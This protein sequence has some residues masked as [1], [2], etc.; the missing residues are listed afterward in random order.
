[1]N[2]IYKVIWSRAKNCYVVVSELAGS[3]V[4]NNSGNRTKVL[5]SAVLTVSLL[6]SFPADSLAVDTATG[7]GAGV[8]YG[9]GSN[10]PKAENV[11]IGKGA[12]ISY[13]GGVGQPS[14]GDIAIG[15]GARTLNY[16]DQ[17][18]GIA[19]G[20]NAF[21]ENMV[22]GLERSFDFNQAGYNSIFGMPYGL[23]KDPTK[24]VTG[25]TIGQNT[26]A[27]S[28]SVMLGTHNYK[29]ALGDISVDT[30]STKSY[31]MSLFS[32]TL[33]ANSFSNGLFS[34]VTGAYSIAS[35]DYN[36]NTLAAGK[37]FGAT[38]TGALNSIESATASSS[39]AGVA[40]SIV[41]TANREFNSN[42]ALIFGAGN[43]ITNSITD[44]SAPTSSG[45]S[46]QALQKTLMASVKKSESGG[47]TL[48]IG[49]G[50]KA[51]YTQKTSIIGVNNTVTGTSGSVSRY[52][53]VNGYKNTASNVQHVSVIGSG[54][55]VKDTDTALLLGDNRTLSGATNSLV[56]GS[57]DNVTT[58]DQQNVVVLGHNANATVAG[59]VALG[60][61]SL[62]AVEAGAAGYDPSTRQASTDTSS[63][64]V[65]TGAAVS[66]GKGTELTRQ[67]TSVAAGTQD[68]DAVNVAQLKQ[69][70][71]AAAEVGK[72]SVVSAG[73][74]ISVQNTAGAG[75][76]ANYQVSLKKDIT[77]DSVTAQ[78]ASVGGIQLNQGN[79]GTIG[80]LQNTT[81][82]PDQIVSGQAATEDQLK[83]VTANVVSYDDASHSS[84][85]LNQ[86]GSS[87]VIKNVGDGSVAEGSKEAVNGGQ[88]YRTNQAVEKNAGDI[89]NLGSS[90]N[91]LGSRLNRVG[92]GAAALAALH[93]QDFD[94]DDKWDFA[95]GYGNYKDAHAA[96]IGAFYRPSEDTLISVGGSFGGGENMVNAGVTFKLGQHNHV[97]RSKV[98]MA[99]EIIDLRAT[100]EMLKNQNAQ[101]LQT[102]KLQGTPAVK[103]L[104]GNFSD[105]PE[106]HWA[107]Q[108]VEGLR[109]RGYLQGYPDGEFK[110]DRTMTRYEYAAI[111]YRALQNGAPVDAGMAR[112][113]EE[114]KPE[115][116]QVQEAERFRV[117][118]ISGKDNDRHKVERVR[119]NSKE[120]KEKKEY[121]DVYGSRIQRD[122]K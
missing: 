108:Y 94:P 75:E 90:V 92:A 3:H 96:A 16:I 31:N 44:I 49:G 64:W 59:G 35:S 79:S 42:G 106:T 81:W 47:A 114:F 83:A 104:E 10:A 18:G 23:P 91:K 78:T 120:N 45:D 68:T 25:L 26:Y 41:G 29:G 71:Q 19:I 33:G 107:Y 115:L 113:V 82:D 112:S 67:I 72:P 95:A 13:Q 7:A 6:A 22:G 37:N 32:T 4:K 89:R 48:A 100:V 73:D 62:A 116:T 118:R 85:T 39:Y 2:K 12:T 80:G 61:E 8:A 17:G 21:V 88:L 28:G 63:A 93:P 87:T 46:A 20:M 54:N 11:A 105:V 97:T 15:G 1:M 5:A 38:I 70:F 40:N 57:A 122:E 102:L 119:V 55:T 74:N 110:G 51:D 121:R 52:N 43:E 98:A 36:T 84:I 77:V 60:S 9:T 24:M 14:T 65:A 101:I 34:S 109:E 86:G 117:D 111:I 58:T 99:K 56:I 30:A 76:A 50:N 69:A 53:M 27:R 103:P 66:V